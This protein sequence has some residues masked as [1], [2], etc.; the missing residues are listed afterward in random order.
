MG[1]LESLQDYILVVGLSSAHPR[2]VDKSRPSL[3]L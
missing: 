3:G 2:T 1:A